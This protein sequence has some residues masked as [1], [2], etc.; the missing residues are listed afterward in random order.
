MAIRYKIKDGKKYVWDDFAK[1]WSFRGAT[2]YYI[3]EGE[4]KDKLPPPIKGARVSGIPELS[5]VLSAPYQAALGAIP[6]G[7]ARNVPVETIKPKE[8][9][10]IEPSTFQKVSAAVSEKGPNTIPSAS[11][12]G[13]A[14]GD[15]AQGI[16]GAVNEYTPWQ[17]AKEI[18][19]IQ[20]ENEQNKKGVSEFSKGVEGYKGQE[21]AYSSG[22]DKLYQ[23]AEP[24]LHN[25]L[26]TTPE[27]IARAKSLNETID[28]IKAQGI[29]SQQEAEALHQANLAQE[30]KWAEQK[31]Q[32][33]IQSRISSVASQAR[34][35]WEPK[36]NRNPIVE[37][38]EEINKRAGEIA[39]NVPKVTP[40]ELKPRPALISTP[41]SMYATRT[42]RPTS[43]ADEYARRYRA[44][45]ARQ[46]G[47]TPSST[48]SM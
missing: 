14:L 46:S 11:R 3:E 2:P 37:M 13:G 18:A 32:D 39:G 35:P 36:G 29:K 28:T 8:E 44:A 30:A 26:A 5:E 25:M 1:K 45:M 27:T 21:A 31:K 47:Y 40:T 34:H 6:V 20:K 15:I 9:E 17:Q 7:K 12:V 42:E 16:F 19:E 43:Y 41:E 24:A 23:Q 10:I 33:E 4:Y 38:D 48:G 22:V